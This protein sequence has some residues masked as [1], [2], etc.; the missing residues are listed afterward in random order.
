MTDET[1][2]QELK[3]VK[4]LAQEL[5][6]VNHNDIDN[7]RISRDLD[8]MSRAPGLTFRTSGT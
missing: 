1:A 3:A 5:I 6:R 4:S 7:R 8:Y 2:D